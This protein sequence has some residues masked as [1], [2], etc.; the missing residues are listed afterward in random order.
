MPYNLI[1]LKILLFQK[2]IPIMSLTCIKIGGNALKTEDQLHRFLDDWQ[3]VFDREQQWVLIH[4]GGP[5]IAGIL[6]RYGIAHE[7]IGGHRKTSSEAIRL[8]EMALKG[9]V[10]GRLVRQLLQRG[11]KALGLSG[12]DAG[13]VR[14]QKRRYGNEDLG[15]VGDI[16]SVDAGL[17]R[18]LLSGGYVPVLAPL[19]LAEDFSAHNVNADMFAAHVAASLKADRFLLMTDVEGFFWD[20]DDPAT[21]ARHIRLNRDGERLARTVTGGMLP[22]M[23]AASIAVEQGVGEVF[24]LNGARAGVLPELFAGKAAGTKITGV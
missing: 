5:A 14:S 17:L 20:R 6:D 13:M 7:F 1:Y 8:V 18:Q 19:A 4:G 9:D 2:N 21:L 3:S 16:S 10:N 24:I 12:M 11:I 22:K 23:E 15:Q